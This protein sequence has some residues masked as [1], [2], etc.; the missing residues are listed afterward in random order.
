MNQFYAAVLPPAGPYCAVGIRG[1]QVRQTFHATYLELEQRGAALAAAGADAY[2]AVCGLNPGATGRKLADVHQLQALFLDIDCG[3]GKGYAVAGEAAQALR[4]FVD[5]HQ[6]PRPAVVSS[7]GGLHVYWPLP[8]PLPPAEWLP[9]AH[10]LRALCQQAGL[11][12]DPGITVDAARILRMP[13]TLNH[14]FVPPR[15]VQVVR[16]AAGPLDP[17]LLRSLAPVAAAAVPDLAAARRFGA[18]S[19]TASLAAGEYPPSEF[20]RLVRSSVKGHG[21]AQIAHAV[22]NAATLEEPLWRAALS[23][24]WRCTDAESAIHLLS[25]A[26]PE[27]SPEKT[28]AK[29]R[30]TGGPATCAWY[31]ANN[32]AACQDCQQTCTSPIT[33]GRKVA[34]AEVANNSYI[35]EAP[36]T[37]AQPEAPP[38]VTIPAYPFPYFRGASGGVYMKSRAK[39]DGEPCEVEIYRYD[40]YLTARYYDSNEH[41]EGDGEMV[42]VH[43]HTPQD[44]VRVFAVPVAQLLVK[45]KM[46]DIMLHHGVVAI[47]KELDLL[48]GYFAASIRN[49]QR[50]YMADRTRSQMG[51]TVDGTGFVIGDREYTLQGVRFSPPSSSTKLLVP[52]MGVQGT[53]ENWKRVAAF[54]DRPGLEP[55]TMAIMFGFGAMLLRRLGGVE[56]R[57][58]AI[59]LMSNQSG[60]GKTTAQM[61]VNSL[62]GHPTQLLMKK[63][64]TLY[65]K[66]QMLGILNTLPAT[67]DEVTNM[68]D[69]D[70]SEFIYDI[71]QGRGRHRMESQSNKLRA[72]TTTWNTFVIS[73]SNSSL[74]DK[75]GRLKSTA[76]G[77]L[78][79][80]IELRI[81]RPLSIPK[82]ESDVVFRLLSEN[83]GHAAPLFVQY[84]L[85]NSD[86]VDKLLRT[87]Q[88]RVDRDFNFN[89]SDR[90]YSHVLTCMVAASVITDTIQLFPHNVQRLYDH[91]RGVFLHIAKTV[92]APVGDPAT[93]ARE[94]LVAFINENVTNTL[95]VDRTPTASGLPMAPVRE[96]RVALKM[97]YEPD[98]RE[99]WIPT[100]LLR[101]YFV[102]RQVDMG[103]AVAALVRAGYLKHG[104]APQAKRIGAGSIYGFGAGP[105]RCYCFDGDQMGVDLTTPAGGQGGAGTSP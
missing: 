89:Q 46:R 66:M 31:R 88:A 37:P 78:R 96:P 93:I 18:D 92:L 74:Y 5:R 61:V 87:T 28:E 98:T 2:F 79:R 64:D 39:E 51:W 94:T 49:L 69:E 103:M 11:R 27:Y 85:Q 15:P 36:A 10:V 99:L 8:E 59:N 17:A 33:L 76:D 35:I 13:G 50:Q 12:I 57:G 82:S 75:L 1:G 68:S 101:D 41:G 20:A 105:T 43:L 6:L 23:I 95:V 55:H 62:H 30:G 67:V 52:M 14:K 9:L 91:A 56:V 58:A 4:G 83:Y 100:T 42:E 21:C 104:G 26:H 25:R 102:D 81:D 47:N 3:P 71:P 44:G 22:R 45:E 34:A 53:L 7:G 19:M 38:P 77:E 97:R 54:Y 16:H 90:F 73:S 48:M 80:L 60:T 40:L 84:V 72:N 63:S 70:L 65:A 32:P 24:A 29:A 86:A